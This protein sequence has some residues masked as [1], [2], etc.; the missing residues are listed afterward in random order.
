MRLPAMKQTWDLAKHRKF[1]Q[2]CLASLMSLSVCL[3]AATSAVLSILSTI[4]KC[5]STRLCT[6]VS[7]SKAYAAPGICLCFK[8]CP[9]WSAMADYL[10]NW[11]RPAVLL[12][13]IFA[14]THILMNSVGHLGTIKMVTPAVSYCQH[15]ESIE[16]RAG[17]YCN[18]LAAQGAASSNEHKAVALCPLGRRGFQMVPARMLTSLH[19]RTLGYHCIACCF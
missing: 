5:S 4:P 9:T 7:S 18:L 13:H 15:L 3:N 1:C 17:A 16:Y 2:R 10:R 8:K 6:R 19:S 12:R 14:E 11:L